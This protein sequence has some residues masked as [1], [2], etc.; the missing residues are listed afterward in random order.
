MKTKSDPP[1]LCCANNV[2]VNNTH[3]FRYYENW[4]ILL[5][6]FNQTWIFSIGFH[7]STQYQIARKSVQWE[8]GAELIQTTERHD[9]QRDYAK[10]PTRKDQKPQLVE[11]RYLAKRCPLNEP[12]SQSQGWFTTVYRLPGYT[13]QQ[14]SDTS[15][16]EW[17]LHLLHEM[18]D[19]RKKRTP[20]RKKAT[21]NWLW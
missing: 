12:R 7:K 16:I 13:C 18:R 21:G 1:F 5:S 15:M 14:W 20:R 9:A 11:S 8:P 6:D 19:W 10:A 3:V 17:L 4:Q 2:A